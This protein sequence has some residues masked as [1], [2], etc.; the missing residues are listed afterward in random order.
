M[1]LLRIFDLA[2][3]M[4]ENDLAWLLPIWQSLIM[5]FF[6]LFLSIFASVTPGLAQ[7]SMTAEEFDAYTLGQ[8]FYYANNGQPYG[9]EEYL[10]NRRVRWSFLDGRCQ[11]GHW[12]EED[13]LIC[14]VYDS[15]PQPQCWS[16]KK[17]ES[18]L[19][20][21]FDGD[22]TALDLYEVEKSDK[23]LMCMGPDLGV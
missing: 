14:F 19:M 4:T 11:D 18:G 10:E 15:E 9:G 23:P 5:R 13:G 20:A 7:S 16:F 22:E 12:Y 6:L 8:T 3:L 17:G 2:S 21:L 1:R